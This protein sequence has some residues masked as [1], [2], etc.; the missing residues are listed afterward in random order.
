MSEREPSP[1]L[2]QEIART[3]QLTIDQAAYVAA[4]TMVE[5]EIYAQVWDAEAY[6]RLVAGAGDRDFVAGWDLA[7]R[8]A[9]NPAA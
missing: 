9:G 5:L 2:I 8:L 1:E 7:A 4:A 6:G 3:Q